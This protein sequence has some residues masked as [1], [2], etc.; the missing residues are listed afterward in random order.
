[1]AKDLAGWQGCGL[2]PGE[3]CRVWSEKKGK[4]IKGEVKEVV[5]AQDE[6]G[7]DMQR[8]AH[9]ND[10]Y[11]NA[12]ARDSAKDTSPGLLRSSLLE[13]VVEIRG[14]KAA[15][16]HPEPEPGV[17]EEATDHVARVKDPGKEASLC[18]CCKAPCIFFNQMKP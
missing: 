9:K 5:S 17:A 4:W 8:H 2:A 16:N 15:I 12:I 3:K 1:M 18:A 11:I 10:Q 14:H 7:P 6:V 13:V